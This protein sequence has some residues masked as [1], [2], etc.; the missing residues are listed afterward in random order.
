VPR[1]G[2][3][4]LV[5]HGLQCSSVAA[6][7]SE[8]GPEAFFDRQMQR[9]LPPH[10]SGEMRVLA[11]S[12]QASIFSANPDVRWDAV[13]GLDD[14]KKLL[15]EAVVYPIRYPQFF[16]GAMSTETSLHNGSLETGAFLLQWL[17]QTNQP[18]PE[19]Q[20]LELSLQ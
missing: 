16:C 14:A 7:D 1:A 9:P 10:L 20:S 17:M 4:D 2:G 13:A 12:I 8:S 5:I 6:E 15:K 3:A 19:R 18:Y 11:E